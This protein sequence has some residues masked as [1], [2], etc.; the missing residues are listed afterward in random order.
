MIDEYIMYAIIC[1]DFE[2]GL[3]RSS[4]SQ[5]RARYLVGGSGGASVTANY[6]AGANSE[7]GVR[8]GK[9]GRGRRI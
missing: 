8:R 9:K 1:L 6:A 5:G 3:V 4:A 2:L 7:W